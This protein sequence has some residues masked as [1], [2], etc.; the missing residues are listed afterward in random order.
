M[1]AALLSGLVFPGLG[2]LLLKRY[3]RGSVLVL[4]ALIATSVIVAD[5]YRRALTIVDRIVLGDVPVGSAAIAQMVADSS[6]GANSPKVTIA[7]I[8]LGACWLIGIVDSYRLGI[9]PVK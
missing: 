9:E 6:N 8:V 3:P 5:A 1:K 4:G 7:I 2:H